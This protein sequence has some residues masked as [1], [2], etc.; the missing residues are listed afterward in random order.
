MT[1]TLADGDLILVRQHDAL[2]VIGALVA[3][4]HPH[5]DLMMVKRVRSRGAHTFAVGS[6]NPTEGTDS[7]HFGS[8][9]PEKLEGLV[10]AARSRDRF[11]VI[12]I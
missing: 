10:T 9:P 8:L 11:Y 4:R 7:R 2:P 3:V 6:D 5:T 12:A 1:P